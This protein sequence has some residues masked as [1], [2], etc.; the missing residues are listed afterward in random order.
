MLPGTSP[1]FDALRSLVLTVLMVLIHRLACVRTSRGARSRDL[2]RHRPQLSHVKCC[3][4][5]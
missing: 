4:F 3:R 5:D 2:E 1:S